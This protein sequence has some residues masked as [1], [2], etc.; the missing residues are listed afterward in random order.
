MD[1]KLFKELKNDLQKRMDR[2][3]L[4]LSESIRMKDE[5]DCI[6]TVALLE[7]YAKGIR[8]IELFDSQKYEAFRHVVENFATVRK[9]SGNADDVDAFIAKM[10]RSANDDNRE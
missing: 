9:A 1:N 4:R 2:I 8:Q 5:L 6:I 3:S 7:E 10:M